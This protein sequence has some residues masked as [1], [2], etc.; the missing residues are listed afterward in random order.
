MTKSIYVG[1]IHINC[2]S[3]EPY[4]DAALFN[5]LNII[6]EEKPDEVIFLGDFLNTPI[7]NPDIVKSMAVWFNEFQQYAGKVFLITGNHDKLPRYQTPA[8]SF[9]EEQ[10]VITGFS[11]Y[12]DD[13]KILVSHN[14][15]GVNI[16]NVNGKVVAAHLGLTGVQ[17]TPGYE[18][19]NSDVLTYTG[20]PR[21]IILGHIHTPSDAIRNGVPV[22]IPGNICPC[23]WSDAPDQRSIIIVTE[24]SI[25]LKTI[26]HIRTKIVYKSTDIIEEKNTIYR[27]VADEAEVDIAVKLDCLKSVVIQKNTKPIVRNMTKESLISTF[28]KQANV[29]ETNVKKRLSECGVNA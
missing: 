22:Y 29:S 1:D 11:T 21:A 6:K 9:L 13:S 23:N 7:L 24:N 15:S 14:H 2:G 26:Y 28:C 12:E 4:V 16:E 10:G 25:T 20:T 17:V 18:Y 27:L 8:T 19:T 3:F 5:V